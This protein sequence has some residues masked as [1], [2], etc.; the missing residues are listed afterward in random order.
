M[1][2]LLNAKAIVLLMS[3][4]PLLACATANNATAPGGYRFS[5][6]WFV[7]KVSW[8][9]LLAKYRGKS[10]IRYLEVGVFEGRS[11]FWMLD[12]VLTGN[13]ASAVAVDHFA[14]DYQKVF[15]DNLRTS[16]K[17][18]RV[19]V[20]KDRSESV[21]RNLQP[22]SFDIVFID[23]SHAARDVLTDSVLSWQLLV[24]GG[25][26]IWDDYG[27]EKPRDEFLTLAKVPED[28]KPKA[29]IDAFLTSFRGELE[30]VQH[31]FQVVVR[32]LAPACQD[33]VC[34]AGRTWY[35]DWGGRR[36]Y[37]R[38]DGRDVPL[39]GEQR[40]ELEKL[41]V[42]TPFGSAE[43]V[44]TDECVSRAPCRSVVEL[45]GLRVP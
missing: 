41:L 22:R 27:N 17:C 7:G 11:L 14:G 19:T 3:V 43:P 6:D 16:G 39:D 8:P 12:N 33:W 45:L 37:R 44:P 25:L 40:A 38:G 28:L 42:D 1:H 10:G 36:L 4:V 20:I 31:D 2:V 5:Q 21:L 15:A 30:V 24:D 18:K 9:D 34:S 26:L 23:G 13:G 32:K 35:Y 29:A